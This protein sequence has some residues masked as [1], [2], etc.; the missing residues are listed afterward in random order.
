MKQR[1]ISAAYQ[2]V[3]QL[4]KVEGLP[5]SVS[6]QLYL[7]KKKLDPYIELEAEKERTL[8]DASGESGTLTPE[9]RR[10]IAK[11][12][13]AEVEW[14]EEVLH[15]VLLPEM[16]DKMGI[17]GEILDKLDGFVTIEEFIGGAGND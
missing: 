11:I 2:A 10:E 17:T 16:I 8:F 15:F 6:M 3:T 5:F 7:L 13:E 1:Q 12:L 9:M 14:N 4:Y